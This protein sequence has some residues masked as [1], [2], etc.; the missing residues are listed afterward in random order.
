MSSVGQDSA[1]Q[2]GVDGTTP[3][4]LFLVDDVQEDPLDGEVPLF[5]EIV[6]TDSAVDVE[7]AADDKAEATNQTEVDE[8]TPAELEAPTPEGDSG[9]PTADED[10]TPNN[11]DPITDDEPE[12]PVLPPAENEEDNEPPAIEESSTVRFEFEVLNSSNGHAVPGDFTATFIEDLVA[13]D[14]DPFAVV[15]DVTHGE[16]VPMRTSQS[17]FSAPARVRNLPGS[18]V[19]RLSD[20]QCLRSDGSTPNV[21]E[22]SHRAYVLDDVALGTN[23]TCTFTYSDTP[24]FIMISIEAPGLDSESMMYLIDGEQYFGHQYIEVNAGQYRIEPI[25]DD[26]ATVS[27]IYCTSEPSGGEASGP[28]FAVPAG[29]GIACTFSFVAEE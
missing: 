3:D 7:E 8:P 26:S 10:S 21:E 13:Y 9:A 27:R 18:T 25:G 15:L 5:D 29:G 16:V 4:E 11:P 6:E 22:V 2:V 12:A 14:E 20:V 24:S 17:A 23:I 19:Y 28:N 1:V